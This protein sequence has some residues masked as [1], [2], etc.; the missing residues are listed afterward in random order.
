MIRIKRIYDS[1]QKEDG[2]RVLVDRLWPRGLS[3][4][5][6]Q[7]DE[8]LKDVAPSDDLRK[9]FGHKPERF[10]EFSR[11]YQAELRQNPAF[12]QL[13]SITKNHKEV[14]LLY[15]AHDEKHNQARVLLGLLGK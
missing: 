13:D 8:W 6:A 4:D 10:D 5:K 1:P 15:S 9:W 14:T 2:Y 7:I 12:E 3:K 11:R